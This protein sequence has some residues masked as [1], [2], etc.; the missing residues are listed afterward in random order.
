MEHQESEPDV[1]ITGEWFCHH[2][3]LSVDDI[4]DY[5]ESDYL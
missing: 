1:G 5:D 4:D 2:C 3:E